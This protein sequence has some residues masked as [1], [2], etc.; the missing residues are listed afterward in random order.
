MSAVTKNIG[1]V[2]LTFAIRSAIITVRLGLAVATWMGTLFWIFHDYARCISGSNDVRIGITNSRSSRNPEAPDAFSSV[3][4]ERSGPKRMEFMG[5][6]PE[7][8]GPYGTV[9]KFLWAYAATN[10]ILGEPQARFSG[11]LPRVLS[12]HRARRTIGRGYRADLVLGCK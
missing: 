10:P 9:L 12:W 1:A 6:R 5:F 2:R 7:R 4:P 3:Y 11:M 8:A